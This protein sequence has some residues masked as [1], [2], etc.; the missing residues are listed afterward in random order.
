[1][2][3]PGNRLRMGGLRRVKW[4]EKEGCWYVRPSYSDPVSGGYERKRHQVSGKLSEEEAQ[5]ACNAWLKR[6]D[7]LHR[8]KR[9]GSLAEE[10][11]DYV[12]MRS[13]TGLKL[14][15]VKQYT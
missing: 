11:L 10:C 6:E 9:C 13:L 2:A 15:S 8:P 7:R 4:D 3:E 5:A 12:R 14:R 1:M